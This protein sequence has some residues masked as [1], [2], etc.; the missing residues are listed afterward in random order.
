M[1]V[2]RKILRACQM[3]DPLE[4]NTTW[5]TYRSLN[6]WN[7]LNV[8]QKYT[9]TPQ[10]YWKQAILHDLKMS[11][12]KSSSV[13]VE[14]NLLKVNNNDTTKTPR[15]VV[16]M[17]LLLDL[18]FLRR[19]FLPYRNQ[20]IDLLFK[21]MDWFLYDRDLC[22][23]RFKQVFSNRGFSK[24]KHLFKYQLIHNFSGFFYIIS[25][26]ITYS[27]QCFWCLANK[28]SYLS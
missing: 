4:H 28:Y 15:N 1:L 10:L 6:F 26:A 9:I 22:H 19:R 14:D 2:F 16:L 23:G 17:H 24:G 13:P 27:Q 18:S 12:L 3:N 8:L 11:F 25:L 21:S 7:F 5:K 20:S